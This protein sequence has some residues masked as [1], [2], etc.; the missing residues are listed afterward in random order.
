MKRLLSALLCILMLFAFGC[1][2]RNETF[3]DPNLGVYK[4][5]TMEY[6]GVTIDAAE[7]FEEGF[8]V[9]LKPNGKCVLKADG[10]S[11]SGK[12][13]LSGNQFTLQ[14]GGLDCTGTLENGQIHLQYD[15]DVVITLV[16]ESYPAPEQIAPAVAESA[17]APALSESPASPAPDASEAEQLIGNAILLNY[18][19]VAITEFY[20]S[21]DPDDWGDCLL[22]DGETIEAKTEDQI[23]FYPIWFDEISGAP[24]KYDVGLYDAEKWNY[25]FYDVTIET[26]DYLMVMPPEDGYA[27]LQVVHADGM[28][29]LYH[30]E[31]YLGETPS[32]S[33]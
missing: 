32:D 31:Y 7:L 26:G 17:E 15:E 3:D 33:D 19:N 29:D 16:N 22:K 18:M 2:T 27:V 14:G 8:S 21:D 25:D 30:G 6:L 28:F 4:A 23:A 9:E 11:S 1:S 13:S 10:E 5:T 24:G 12:W 20:I